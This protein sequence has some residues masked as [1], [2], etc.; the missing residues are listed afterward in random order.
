MANNKVIFGNNTLIDLTNDTVDAEHLLSGYTAHD[1]SGQ[2]ITGTASSGSVSLSYVVALS[3]TALRNCTINVLD[4]NDNIV[5]TTIFSNN[6]KAQVSLPSTGTYTFSVT[7]V[8][9]VNLSSNATILN[10]PINVTDMN[11]D[12]VDI[13]S[14]NSS[15]IAGSNIEDVGLYD[16]NTTY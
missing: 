10:T 7:Y 16:F 14:F 9:A 5:T 6:G 1:A 11:G 13:T 3:T 15:G 2:I 8:A 12:T 4:E